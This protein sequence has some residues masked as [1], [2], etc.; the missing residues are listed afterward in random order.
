MSGDLKNVVKF[1]KASD[2][3]KYVAHMKDGS[4]VKFGHKNYQHYKDTVPKSMGGGQW[5][6]KDHHDSTRRASYRARH[7]A[8]KTKS[9]GLAYK[10]Q[11]SPA[12]FSYY[13][14]W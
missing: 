12:W 2:S 1:T 9:G 6:H 11:Y 8:I 13:Y 5:S 10:K 14:L 7:G 3:H 4:N